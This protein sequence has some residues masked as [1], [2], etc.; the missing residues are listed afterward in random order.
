VAG[1]CALEAIANAFPNR[2]D[3]MIHTHK[4]NHHVERKK[5]AWLNED[6]VESILREMHIHF[7]RVMSLE[8]ITSDG[9]PTFIVANSYHW[10]TYRIYNGTYHRFDGFGYDNPERINENIEILLRNALRT[11]EIDGCYV[12]SSSTPTSDQRQRI[13]RIDSGTHTPVPPPPT[14]RP[15]E[16]RLPT[17]EEIESIDNELQLADIRNQL[18]PPRHISQV[19]AALRLSLID[20]IQ[21]RIQTLR[22][23]QIIDDAQLAQQIADRELAAQQQRMEFAK[24]NG[25]GKGGGRGG[26]KGGRGGGKGGRGGGKGGDM[27]GGK[28]GGKSGGKGGKHN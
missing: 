24:G 8:D 11:R 26:G 6:D 19:K 25:G 13:M 4:F 10:F 3:D 21:A 27:G 5:Y 1:G 23:K 28:G 15:T 2:V 20:V 17:A 12:V 22:E 16:P 14:Q 9:R 7:R 18:I